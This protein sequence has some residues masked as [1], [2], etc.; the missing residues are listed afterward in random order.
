VS[1][2]RRNSTAELLQWFGLLGAP[3]VW[4]AHL[5]AGWSLVVVR[6]SPVGSSWG[7]NADAWEIALT[8]AA[9]AVALLA[10]AAAVALY[11]ETR[12]IHYTDPPPEGRRHF[13]VAA[14]S[15]GNVLFI[16]AIVVSG[17]GVLSYGG[18][19]QS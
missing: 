8:A 19:R 1:R 7:V 13:F 5:V 3:I 17:V 4:F 10:E 9:A 11:L 16:A 18:C 15:I 12:T 14:A 6:C 2:L